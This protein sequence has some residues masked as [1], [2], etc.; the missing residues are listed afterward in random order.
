MVNWKDPESTHRVIATLLAINPNIKLDYHAMAALFGQGTTNYTIENQFRKWRKLAEEIKTEAEEKGINI[1]SIPRG[2]PGTGT[3]RTPRRT[4]GGITKPASASSTGRSKK[5]VS[6]SLST[7]TK[8]GRLAGQNLMEA[9]FIDDDNE[10]NHDDS[11]I[12]VKLKIKSEKPDV[13]TSIE[14]PDCSVP[15]ASNPGS[16]VGVVI[17][18]RENTA[19][20]S[21]PNKN[22]GKTAFGSRAHKADETSISLDTDGDEPMG[23]EQGAL[24]FQRLRTRD[25]DV[26]YRVAGHEEYDTDSTYA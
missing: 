8:N 25:S 18:K 23:T 12:D 16:L 1:A 2:H 21:T 3:P 19:A 13:I 9:I 26:S 11:D 22:K 7:P 24:D 10:S 5:S 17:T 6:N 14:T 4:R 15:D 20:Y